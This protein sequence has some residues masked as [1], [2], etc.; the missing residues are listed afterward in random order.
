[1][2]HI[3][4]EQYGRNANIVPDQLFVMFWDTSAQYCSNN[5]A[6]I[7]IV[8]KQNNMA[9]IHIVPELTTAFQNNMEAIHIVPE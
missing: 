9:A 8:L 7:Y 1:M 4:P 6:V 5:M 2:I 3:T